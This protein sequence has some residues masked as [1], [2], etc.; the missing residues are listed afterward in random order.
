MLHWSPWGPK[1]IGTMVVVLALVSNTDLL[2]LKQGWLQLCQKRQRAPKLVDHCWNDQVDCSSVFRCDVRCSLGGLGSY[3]MLSDDFALPSHVPKVYFTNSDWIKVSLS[4]LVPCLESGST[5]GIIIAL[6]LS[7]P[8]VHNAKA[9][10]MFA[11][12]MG[13]FASR[14]LTTRE[15]DV[16]CSLLYK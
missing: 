16:C 4:W 9:A 3:S 13:S 2:L 5:G 7:S 14:T 12:S 1:Q 15:T 6:I 11:T 10:I 8:Q